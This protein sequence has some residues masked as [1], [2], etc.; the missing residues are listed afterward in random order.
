MALTLSASSSVGVRRERSLCGTASE[1]AGLRARQSHCRGQ[2]FESPHLHHRFQTPSTSAAASRRLLGLWGRPEVFPSSPP[3]P[4]LLRH[5][6]CGRSRSLVGRQHS[7]GLRLRRV[8]SLP[9][10]IT[11][12]RGCVT[13]LPGRVTSLPERVTSLPGRV[14]SLPKRV[15]LLPGRVTSLP[16]CVTSLPGCVTLLDTRVT[17]LCWRV[18]SFTE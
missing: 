18:P 5:A 16:G 13:L 17:S 2:G 4:P 6:L 1:P 9:G 3:N 10:C 8:T 14:T 12:L 15:T 11:S 7:V